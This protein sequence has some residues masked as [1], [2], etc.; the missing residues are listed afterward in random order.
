MLT[1]PNDSARLGP[2]SLALS[3]IILTT[4]IAHHLDYRVSCNKVELTE[5]GF[6]PL[7]SFLSQ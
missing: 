7:L 6:F 4:L 3:K 5:V 2:S 1:F